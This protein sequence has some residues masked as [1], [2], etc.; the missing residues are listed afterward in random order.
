MAFR[1]SSREITN[2]ANAINETS[3]LAIRSRCARCD[4]GDIDDAIR[5]FG[6]AIRKSVQFPAE[7]GEFE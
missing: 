2:T 6:E 4:G 5:M 7:G 1:T 3:T